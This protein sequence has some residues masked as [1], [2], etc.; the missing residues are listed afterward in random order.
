MP[1]YNKWNCDNAHVIQ[2]YI[3][4][5]G[6]LIFYKNISFQVTNLENLLKDQDKIIIVPVKI[7]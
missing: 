1:K 2:A 4:E 6:L 7:K 3:L 5:R